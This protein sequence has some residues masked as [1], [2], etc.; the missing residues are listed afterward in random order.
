MSNERTKFLG[1]TTKSSTTSLKS[2][3]YTIQ[4]NQEKKE[5]VVVPRN[6]D[7]TDNSENVGTHTMIKLT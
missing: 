7:F 4:N 2:P 5:F 1:T 6:L 3:L